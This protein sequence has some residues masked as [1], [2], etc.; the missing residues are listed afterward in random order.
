MKHYFNYELAKKLCDKAGGS[1][2]DSVPDVYDKKSH[3]RVEWDYHLM[4][5]NGYYEGYW[6]F[7]LKIPRNNP[8]AFVL[9][10]TRGNPRKVSAYDLKDYLCQ[11]FDEVISEVL[12]GAGIGMDFVNEKIYPG[13]PDYNPNIPFAQEHGYHFGRAH[14]EYTG[15]LKEG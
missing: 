1:G 9:T 11:L 14:Y 12:E 6:N 8:M 5:S 4:N 10:G 13:D 15:E 7:I 2:L 3:I